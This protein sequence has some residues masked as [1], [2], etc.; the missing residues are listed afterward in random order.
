MKVVI[1]GGGIAGLTMALHLK[2]K[3]WEVVVCEKAVSLPNRGH[4][5]LMNYEGLS[6]L[7]EFFSK[8]K[9]HL[10]KQHVNLFSLKR[11]NDE[12]KIKIQ[13]NDWYCLKT[14]RCD[15]FSLFFFY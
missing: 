10:M 11:P 14:N 7:S 6:V 2:R 8:T 1:I 12:E 13:L 9:A 15:F 3:N 5:F 4:A